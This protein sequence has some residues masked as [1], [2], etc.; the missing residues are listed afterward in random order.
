MRRESAGA[1]LESIPKPQAH[2]VDGYRIGGAWL[3]RYRAGSATSVVGI[4]SE[5]RCGV[6]GCGSDSGIER[7]LSCLRADLSACVP[8][9]TVHATGRACVTL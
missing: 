2:V 4:D 8:G 9:G 1:T 6:L 3:I 7:R 5:D